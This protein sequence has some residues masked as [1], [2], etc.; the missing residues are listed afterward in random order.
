M[1]G[2]LSGN[3]G[4][5]PR[6]LSGHFERT[7]VRR[8]IGAGLSLRYR[9][10][11]DGLRAVAV[12]SVLVFHFFPTALPLGYLG[13][14]IFFVISGF[15]IT[16]QISAEMKE[17]RF[18]FRRFYWR[19]IRR[20]L[21]AA[22]TVMLV[23]SLAALFIL[24][25]PDLVRY[26]YSLASSIGF[27]A[28]MYFWRTG[29]YFGSSDELKP[30]LHMWSLG[31][32][33]QFYLVF[34]LFLFILVRMTRKVPVWVTLIALFAAGSLMANIFLIHIGGE[35]PAFFLLPTR[36]WQ[37]GVGALAALAHGAERP[38]VNRWLI[39]GAALL[40][41]ANFV[42]KV[43]PLPDALALTL[44]TGLLL[45]RPMADDLWLTRALRAGP[46]RAVGLISFSLYLWHWPIVSFLRY[47]HVD[48][49]PMGALVAGI[50]ATFVLSY[51]SW[52]FIENPCRDNANRRKVVLLVCSFVLLGIGFA[53][54]S[55]KEEGFRGRHSAL[56]NSLSGAI[57]T[58][59][60]CSV[61][62]YFPYGGSRACA[63]GHAEG[64][65]Y[66]IALMGN[67]HAQ[68][69]GPAFTAALDAAGKRGVIVPLNN[70]VPSP[71]INLTRDCNRL[72]RQNFEAVRDD[73]KVSRVIIALTWGP[74]DLVTEDG[75]AVMDT[76]HSRMGAAILALADDLRAAGKEVYV[77][78]PIAIPGYDMASELSRTLMFSDA[79]PDA[80]VA[81][82]TREPRA[83]FEA[84]Y[85]PLVAQ[86]QA[87]LGDHLLLPHETLCD[88][89]ACYFWKDMT[90]Y[91]ADSNHLGAKAALL[92]TPLFERAVSPQPAPE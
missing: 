71:T 13:V 68:M 80:L 21:P 27:I 66:D 4:V 60:R 46:V 70:C 90:T 75:V 1:L 69:Y 22:L 84:E 89:D 83:Q 40:G 77:V 18:T 87:A 26:A 56:V 31:V 7:R 91:Y 35:T 38:A 17:G 62:S 48:G 11:I 44:V 32:E 2:I 49:V 86:L 41:A 47:M 37:F 82:R 61:A 52:R 24:T 23:T 5:G 92:M 51:L 39:Y 16:S 81:A 42:F 36:A 20:I 54:L 73:A 19:R 64:S 53:A 30:L 14:D 55:V 50:V 33:E 85:G 34:P 28:N 57:Q 59:F 74:K 3:Q 12:L 43:A 10:E 15:L 45:A 25:P 29:G 72:A 65:D 88:A 58:N 6:I 63:A 76:D 9:T 78:G 79:D 8:D 67:S